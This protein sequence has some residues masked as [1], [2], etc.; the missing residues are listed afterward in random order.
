MDFLSPNRIKPLLTSV[1][2]FTV[3]VLKISNTFHFL[4]SNK[5]LVI[6]ASIHKMLVGITNVEDP[7]QTA[8]EE[9]LKHLR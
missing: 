1:K 6:R 5:M 7:D 3:N 8:T 2:L 4:F 9:T